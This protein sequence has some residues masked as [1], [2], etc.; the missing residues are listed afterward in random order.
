MKRTVTQNS[1]SAP[2]PIQAPRVVRA[3]KRSAWLP[4]T[5]LWGGVPWLGGLVSFRLAG[6]QAL[7]GPAFGFPHRRS[8]MDRI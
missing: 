3:T 7:D 6:R 2:M 4:T 5:Q 8:W 1:T